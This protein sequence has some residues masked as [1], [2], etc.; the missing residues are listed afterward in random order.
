MTDALNILLRF[1]D[2]SQVAFVKVAGRCSDMREI[3]RGHRAKLLSDRDQPAIVHPVEDVIMERN[4]IAN[5]GQCFLISSVR[6]G[7]DSQ[8]FQLRVLLEV[9][10]DCTVALRR[11][12]VELI[13]HDS[14]K[15]F[16]FPFPHSLPATRVEGLHRSNDDW[17]AT[18]HTVVGSLPSHFNVTLQSCSC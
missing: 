13:T 3:E 4:G 7:C 5:L 2:A 14:T 18:P 11:A 8:D 15:L 9:I 17:F 10:E 16:W 12:M 1:H 6:R